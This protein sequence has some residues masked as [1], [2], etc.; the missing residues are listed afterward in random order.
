MIIGGGTEISR[1]NVILLPMFASATVALVDNC[2][3]MEK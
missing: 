2:I 3:Y 1:E